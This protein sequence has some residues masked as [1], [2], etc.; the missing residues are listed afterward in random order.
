V[1]RREAEESERTDASRE[2]VRSIVDAIE[3]SGKP[4][5]R[6]SELETGI[7]HDG[8]ALIRPLAGLA[9]PPTVRD[10]AVL[11]I[12]GG[13]MAAIKQSV[14]IAR[15]PEDV[16]AYLDDFTRHGEWQT[17][18]VSAR[19]DTEGP[20]RVGTRITEVRRVGKREQP[21]PIEIT[22]HDPPRSFAFRGTDGPI[23]PVG[24]GTIEPIGD[25]SSSRFTLELEL[26]GHGF[27]KLIAPLA[28]KQAAKDIP[29]NQRRLKELLESGAA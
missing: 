15:R 29:T 9:A 25:G 22:E 11:T 19:V 23:R 14:E 18:L 27:G 5:P 3:Q 4:R 7:K 2:S 13:T 1:E 10:D 21:V 24:K 16:F 20:V 26:N 17:N 6:E 12:R 28:R 8:A